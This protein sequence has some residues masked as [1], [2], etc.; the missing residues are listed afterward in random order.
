MIEM[1]LTSIFAG[2][3][4]GFITGIGATFVLMVLIDLQIKKGGN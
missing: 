1:H 2:F 3:C 4:L